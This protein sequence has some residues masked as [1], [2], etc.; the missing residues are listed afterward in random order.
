MTQLTRISMGFLALVVLALGA[1]AQEKK[2]APAAAPQKISF[3]KQI[4]PIFQGVCVGC[5]QPAKSKGNYVM[6][7]RDRML[8]AG[9]SK[10][11]AVVP[12]DPAKSNLLKLVT[13][14]K[15]E[16]EMPKGKK[17]LSQV[18]IDLVKKWIAEGAVDDTPVNAKAKF[19]VDHPPVYTRPPVLPALDFSPDGE[20]LAIAGF[21]EVL[22]WKADGSERVARLVGLSERIQSVRFSPDGKS[23]AAVGGLPGRIGEVQIWDLEKKNLTLSVP[24]TYDTLNGVSWSPDGSKLAFGCG[25]NTVRAIDVKKGDQILYNL[26]HSD[27]SLGTVFSADGSHIA[28]AGRDGSLKLIEVATQRFVDNITSITPGALKG[29]LI[30]V[31]RHPSRDEVVIGGADGAPKVYRMHRIVARQIGDDS[32][33]IKEL[34]AMQGRVWSVAVSPD[35][36]RIAAGSGLDGKGEVAVTAYEMNPAPP[37]NLKAILAKEAAKRSVDEQKALD[38]FTGEGVK[39]LWKKSVETGIVYSVAFRSTGGVVAAACSDGMV[40]LYDLETGNVVKEFSPAPIE[41][42]A[43][44]TGD[45]P[46]QT[47][48]RIDERKERDVLPAGAKLASIE[49]LPAE[50]RFTRP[51]EY[52]QLVVTGRLETGEAIDITRMVD[53]KIS[54]DIADVSQGGLIQPK[55]DGEAKVAFTLAGKSV[56]V[57]VAVT[58]LK[59]E[60]KADFIRDV[61]PVISRVG[62]N[63]G[64]C[65]GS[66]KGRNGFKLSLRGYDAILDVRSLTDDLAS[67]RVNVASPDD[68]L[69]LLKTTGA[70]PHEGGRVVQHGDTYYQILRAW[71]AQ[72]ATLDTAAARVK[73][74]EVVP[75]NP[76]IERIGSRQQIRVVAT[77][78]DGK[79]R[80][81]TREAYIESGNTEVAT[82][83]RS[84]VMLAIR[85][86]EAP[87]L[88]RYEGSYAAT[89]LTVM[90]DRKGFTWEQPPAYNKIDEL[91]A[92]KWQRLKVK[93]SGLCTDAEFVRRVYLD[94]T[95][96]PPSSEETRAFMADATESKAKREAL[97]T[98]LIG[99]DAYVDHWTN[100]WADLLQV[101]RKWL[102]PEGAASFRKWIRDQVA[103]NVPYDQFVRSIIAA[104]GSNKENPPASYYKILRDPQNTTENTTH[105]F[106]A[107]RF[108]CSKCHDHPFERWTQDQYYE[109]AAYFARVGL[110]TDPASGDKKIGGTAVEGAKPLYEIVYEKDSGEVT[111][112]RT[113]KVTPPKFPYDCKYDAPEKATRRQQLAAWITSA[114]NAYFAKS[115]VNRL[116]GYLFGIGIIEPI[117]DIRAGNP[118]SNPQLLEYLTGE[119]LK[120]NFNTR[121]VV[122][123]LC[124]SRVYQLSVSSNEWNKDDRINYSHA[125]ARRLPA[126]VIFDSVHLVVGSVSKIPG[127]PA[128]T[129]AAA[130]PDSGVE[131]P[132]GFLGTF[133]RPPRESA[134]ECER[135]SELRLGAVMSLISGPTIADAIA[136]PQN[137]LAKLAKA[138]PDDAKLVDEIFMRI[139]NRPARPEEIK[140]ALES[141]KTI[142][143]DHARLTGMRDRREEEWKV[144]EPKLQKDRLDAIE[145]SKGE[146]AAYEKEIAPRVA[147]AEK[148]RADEI[149]KREGEVKEYEAKLPEHVTEYEK[150]HKSATEWFPLL[151]AKL[152]ASN[153]ATLSAQPDL[154]VIAAGKNGK[155]NYVFTAQ[156]SLKGIRSIRLEA[157]QDDRVPTK[158]PGRAPD[159]NFVL[160]QFELQAASKAEP[161]KPAKVSLQNA[162]ADFSQK[163]FDVKNAIDGTP[164]N[165]R[166]WAVSPLPGMTHW[167]TFETKE[168]LGYDGGTI[169]TFT[170]RQTFNQND[171]ML[172]RFRLSVTTEEKAGLS[173]SDELRAVFVTEADKRTDVQ[174]DYLSKVVKV[175]DPE[176]RKLQ[177]ALGDAKKPLP[178]D[179]HLK[180]LQDSLTMVSKPVPLDFALS[181]LRAD[182]DQSTKQAADARLTSAQD[183][184]WA[185]INS[186]AFLFNR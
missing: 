77:Y 53:A 96:L 67:R 33:K 111:H 2:D 103:T 162:K 181:Q 138:E 87:V 60:Y 6:T 152:E 95:G 37:D 161:A 154:S 72:G 178:V 10:L 168:P 170:L 179:P 147:E 15:G 74:I 18:E 20:L 116:W 26:S 126:E 156:T 4:R 69:M 121:H 3:D 76:T 113:G 133:G 8:A 173:L 13:P 1:T 70:V 112:D 65:H 61:N 50:I 24:V 104:D 159:G 129:R 17:A 108:N 124:K 160:V 36:K 38:K 180:E 14:E 79:T 109:T 28:S 80:D 130:L 167:A 145:K 43:A 55:A 16:A 94:L 106:L 140:M 174:K 97:V 91:V 85:R 5:H 86:G 34:P 52:A 66:A 21:H 25:D 30:A 107:V 122:E 27:W 151:P 153:G 71:I 99:S 148:K 132:S 183:L 141:L 163:D 81:V 73:K 131:L 164:D 169:L 182:A 62:C 135:T 7:S 102:A 143:D 117:D 149:A 158:G 165:N 78:A 11:P 23:L 9:E 144:L 123:L 64:T 157:L 171:F 119:F 63:A 98:K 142:S 118:A 100:K 101:N 83:D 84:G 75:S 19:D 29:G 46:I 48:L 89:T 134:C 166:G 177:T 127:V 128:G 31:A 175:L 137:G 90:G 115:Y 184:A 150:K 47:T 32:N 44:K 57:P 93:P 41:V 172:S 42:P 54:A 136:D 40:R 185:L 146:L 105:L 155:G 139:L 120:S 58:G 39:P 35:A 125:M 82:P 88:A 45:A 110:K 59:E 12:G 176:L 92:G 51:Y 56:S 49:V 186:P 114:D 22:L 68:S